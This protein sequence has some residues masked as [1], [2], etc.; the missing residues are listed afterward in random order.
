MVGALGRLV[1]FTMDTAL[2]VSVVESIDMP[3]SL[4]GTV[5]LWAIFDSTSKVTAP[6]ASLMTVLVAV[7]FAAVSERRRC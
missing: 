6:S 2:K 7:P 4:T 1:A 5:T 3:S